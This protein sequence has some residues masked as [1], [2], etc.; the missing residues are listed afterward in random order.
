MRKKLDDASKTISQFD[1]GLLDKERERSERTTALLAELMADISNLWQGLSQN[2]TQT[3]RRALVKAISAFIDGHLNC[4]WEYFL[5]KEQFGQINLS[6]AEK[7]VLR[8]QRAEIKS[9]GIA[10]LRNNHA[11][12]T[13]RVLLTARLWRR[14]AGANEGGFDNNSSEWESFKSF[15]TLRNRLVHPRSSRGSSGGGRRC[16]YSDKRIKVVLG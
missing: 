7:E 13:D 5:H 12:H 14:N 10:R 9:N 3:E 8:Q 4:S 1:P 6:S 11:T 16:R 15:T 2:D